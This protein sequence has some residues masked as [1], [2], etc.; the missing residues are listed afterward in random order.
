VL[1]GRT[2]TTVSFEIHQ[3]FMLLGP[4]LLVGFAR[5]VEAIVF[6]SGSDFVQEFLLA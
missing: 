4:E 3:L 6:P 5:G 2:A 1:Q